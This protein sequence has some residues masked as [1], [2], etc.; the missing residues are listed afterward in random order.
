MQTQQSSPP[1]A[2]IEFALIHF[3]DLTSKTTDEVVPANVLN[4]ENTYLS[5]LPA[6][7]RVAIAEYATR[8]DMPPEFVVELAIAHFLDPDSITFDDCQVVLVRDRLELL[9]NHQQVVAA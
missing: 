3:L 5:E 2:V 7:I 1:Y 8:N 4:D 9:L 6:F